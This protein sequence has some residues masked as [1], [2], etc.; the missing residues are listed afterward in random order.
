[1][2]DTPSTPVFPAFL[3]FLVGAAVGAVVV[4]LTTSRTGPK[5]RRDLKNLARRSRARVHKAVEGFRGPGLRSKRHF[6]W[7]TAGPNPVIQVS[8]GDLPG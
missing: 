7:H 8:V 3:T 2:S 5:V 1:M 6:V 4:A